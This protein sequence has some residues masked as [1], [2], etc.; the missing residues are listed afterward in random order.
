MECVWFTDAGVSRKVTLQ[1]VYLFGAIS[2]IALHELPFLY[3]VVETR[4]RYLSE[5]ACK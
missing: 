1:F 2:R 4:S 3:K 5:S